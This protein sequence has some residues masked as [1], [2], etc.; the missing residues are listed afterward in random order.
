M[1]K[2]DN[3]IKGSIVLVIGLGESGCY[4]AIWYHRH[5]ARLRIVDTKI[6]P[7][8]LC[9]LKHLV[10]DSLIEYNLGYAGNFKVD[11]LEGVS[12]VILSPGLSPNSIV[13]KDIIDK[14][15][16][17]NIEIIGEIEVFARAIEY[18][19]YSIGYNPK[20]I[21][22]T[23]TNG[24][25][26]VT[27]LTYKILNDCGIS[28]QIAG[29]IGP[30]SIRVL[31]DVID[32]ASLPKV[33][34]LELSSFQINSM[35]SLHPEI[36]V[37]LNLT[38]DHIDWHGS[39]ENYWESKNKLLRLSKTAL[40]NRSDHLVLRMSFELKNK[41]INS[42]GIDEPT[43]IGDVGVS[44]KGDQK[45][46]VYSYRNDLFLNDT[47]RLNQNNFEY[48][49]PTSSLKIKGM[50][51]ILNVLASIKLCKYVGLKTAE[52][53][54]ALFNY[55]GEPHRIQWICM[56]NDVNYIDDS[57]STNVASTLAAL[58]SMDSKS[59]LILGG[60]GKN[61]D[62]LPL[63]PDLIR[64]TRAVVLIGT[65]SSEIASILDKTSLPYRFAHDM[66]EA[67]EISSE[68]AN[69]GDTVLLSPACSS[70]D[71]FNGYAHRG[72]IFVDC[73]KSLL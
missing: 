66:K 14:A 17:I 46:L 26:T 50:H 7:V 49:L 43:K 40:I 52:I 72:K 67:V 32:S 69:S 34:V 29:N 73:V 6:N 71:M 27:C 65:T 58:Q 61:Q 13:V 21:A 70:F 37:L 5:G 4:S 1:C 48:L 68:L 19:R 23:G 59:I 18:M 16:S 11:L 8:G 56:V 64:Y 9:K 38:E 51:N 63:I 45:W 55:E 36:S 3:D 25:T 60:M 39:K 44:L 33:W 22:I 15:K 35:Y 20:I 31:M 57:K 62:F 53:L 54:P 41:I 24:K 12:L 28:V 42:F 30:A 10:N 2:L 47:D